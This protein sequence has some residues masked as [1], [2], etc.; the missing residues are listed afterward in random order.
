MDA[1]NVPAKFEVRI[2][3]RSWDKWL[4]VAAQTVRS[5]CKVLSIVHVGYV[6]YFR[7]QQRQRTLYMVSESHTKR[8]F[9]I[10]AAFKES[11]TLNLAQ[12]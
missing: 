8:Y 1:V 5:R 4:A 12:M 6:Y 10:F 3:T 2:F 9:A 7:V 11:M